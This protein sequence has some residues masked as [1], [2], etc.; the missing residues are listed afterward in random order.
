MA[1]NTIIWRYV[2]F[3]AIMGSYY[4][5]SAKTTLLTPA[6]SVSKPKLVISDT[7]K[8]PAL[9]YISRRLFF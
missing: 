6:E 1:N 4:D 5:S 2:Y 3:I 9:L 7:A 8:S